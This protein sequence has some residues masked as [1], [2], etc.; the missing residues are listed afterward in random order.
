MKSIATHNK[1]GMKVKIFNTVGTPNTN[2]SLILN[3]DDGTANFPNDFNLLFLQIK[4]K[5]NKIAR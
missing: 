4:I 3:N 1:L 5:L 2:G